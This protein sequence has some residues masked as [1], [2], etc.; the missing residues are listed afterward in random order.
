MKKI[1]SKCKNE[2]KISSVVLGTG[3]S[4]PQPVRHWRCQKCEHKEKL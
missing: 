1:C 4:I 3:G 2:M